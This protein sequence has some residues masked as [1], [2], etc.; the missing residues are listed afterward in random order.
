MMRAPGPPVSSG[1]WLDTEDHRAWLAGQ[2]RDQLD[3]FR[4]ALRPEGGFYTLAQ[5]GSPRA[6]ALQELHGTTRMI[7]SYALAELCGLDGAGIVDHGMRHL[8]A[9]H[10]DKANGGWFWGVE[11]TTAT[12]RSKMA[13]GHVFTL[14]A[15]SSASLIDHPDAPALLD[16]AA[17]VL[18]THFWEDGPGLLGADFDERWQPLDAYRGMNANM[19]GVE[20]L[21]AAF[22]ATGRETFLARAGSILEFFL[23]RQAPRY[24]WRIPEHYTSGW[25][26]DALH[27]GD[28]MFRPA[29]TTPGHALEFSRLLLQHWDLAGRPNGDVPEIARNLTETALEDSWDID[30]GGLVYT[31]GFDG[32]PLDRTRYWWPVTEGIGSLAALIKLERDGEDEDWYQRLWHFASEHLI[33]HRHG[34]WFPALDDNDRP[35]ETQFKGK[36]DVYHSLQATLYPLAPGLSDQARS[37]PDLSG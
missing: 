3:F 34:G 36:P 11:G 24:Q 12:D 17:G 18:E 10:R 31:V 20:A 8:A 30:F 21:L 27:A 23:H 1:F 28:P 26:I 35:V 6:D 25:E 9:A 29:G 13:Y 7:H 37:L 14:L 5:D 19:H 16:E 15:A 2:S 32:E 4:A 22:E 33:D